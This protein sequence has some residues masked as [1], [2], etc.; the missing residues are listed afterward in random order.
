MNVSGTAPYDIDFNNAPLVG[1]FISATAGAAAPNTIRNLVISSTS[2][3]ATNAVGS[4]TVFV[5]VSET[6]ATFKAGNGTLVWSAGGT[7]SGPV[8][9]N[10]GTYI[11]S[12]PQASAITQVTAAST[13]GGSGT[14]GSI[15]STFGTIQPGSTLLNPGVLTASGNI[16]LSGSTSVVP[17]LTG[18]GQ[19]VG[20]D[21]VV[22]GGVLDYGGATVKHNGLPGA[23]LP[24]GSVY[25]LFNASRYRNSISSLVALTTYAGETLTF[26]G[27]GVGG[28]FTTGTVGNGQSLTFTPSSGQLAIVPGP[29][30]LMALGVGAA[31]CDLVA[32]RRRAA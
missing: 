21:A 18:N 12:A 3:T 16:T 1:G 10:V 7:Y 27:P 28:A 11:N 20:Y 31:A 30:S 29:T 8:S 6:A 32:R 5:G 4:Q 26:T 13:L 2:Q 22:A 15:V 24:N 19:G 17:Q 25:Q 23:A 14:F 9:F